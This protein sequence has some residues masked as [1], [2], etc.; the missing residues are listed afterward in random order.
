MSKNLC[1]RGRP[2]GRKS[3][4]YPFLFI[5]LSSILGLRTTIS[6]AESTLISASSTDRILVSPF[7][8]GGDFT[9]RT[10][11]QSLSLN[12]LRG[13]VVVLLF[14]YLSCPETCPRMFGTLVKV[15]EAL[16]SQ[17]KSGVHI[18]FI[19]LD[20][21]RDSPQKLEAYLSRFPF[22]ATGLTGSQATIDDVVDRYGAQ[23]HRVELPGSKIK[24]ALEHSSAI[25]LI[26]TN[27]QL[28]SLFRYDASPKV[29]AEEIRNLQ[30]S[31]SP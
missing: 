29:L 21:E 7:P 18:L 19:T 2:E 12:A 23:Y 1:H 6:L 8:S 31:R 9:L 10:S 11:N 27:G 16:N 24:Y 17:E 25:Y 13:Q 26:D 20:P 5:A 15:S 4:L 3:Y 28:K 22:R 14:G 30:A